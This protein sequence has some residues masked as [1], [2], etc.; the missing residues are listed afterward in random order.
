MFIYLLYLCLFTY[1]TYVY[2]LIIPMLVH[3]RHQKHHKRVAGPVLRSPGAL[4]TSPQERKT[5]LESSV[6]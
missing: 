2:S 1:Y 4:A 6:I 5:I 3:Q